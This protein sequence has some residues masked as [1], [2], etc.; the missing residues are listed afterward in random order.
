MI[1][2]V[3]TIKSMGGSM[4]TRDFEFKDQKAYD[5]WWEMHT[6]DHSKGKIIGIHEEV[7][8]DKLN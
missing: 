3:A 2:V 7:D 8:T 1:K 4:N 5:A 6:K